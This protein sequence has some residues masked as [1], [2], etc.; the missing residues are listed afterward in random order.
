ML[1]A[2]GYTHI[3]SN[4]F[5]DCI[6]WFSWFRNQSDVLGRRCFYYRCIWNLGNFDAILLRKIQ[7]KLQ[8][9]Y[10]NVGHKSGFKRFGMVFNLI[11]K[12]KNV[13]NVNS[14]KIII[15]TCHYLESHVLFLNWLSFDLFSSFPVNW[16]HH[17][18]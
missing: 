10:L 18:C 13:F 3:F 7:T 8:Q 14:L 1:G 12:R 15:L 6:A 4:S 5:W 17:Y 9:F 11:Y 16:Y 2:V